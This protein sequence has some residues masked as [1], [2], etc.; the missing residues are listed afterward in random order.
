MPFIPPPSMVRIR[1]PLPPMGDLPTARRTA[2][3]SPAT[4]SAGV[5]FAA[6]LMRRVLRTVSWSR[7][8]NYV[9]SRLSGPKSMVETGNGQIDAKLTV[10][11]PPEFHIAGANPRLGAQH[12]REKRPQCELT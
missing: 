9:N 6:S 12:A 7:W 3:F 2:S 11:M 8:K 10:S 1:R 5:S 4:P